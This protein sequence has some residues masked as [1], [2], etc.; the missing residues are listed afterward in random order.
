MPR[1]RRRR[2]RSRTSATWRTEIAAVGSS[3]STMRGSERRVRAM[4]TACRWPPDIRRTRSRGRVSDLS[5]RK[6]SPRGGSWRRGRGPGTGRPRRVSLAAEEDVRGGRQVVAEREV[7]VDDLDARRA[8]VARAGG[9]APARR[10]GGSR[11]W[12]GAEVAGD[13]LAPACDLPAPLSPMSPRTSPAPRSRV[14][15][16]Q[17]LDGAEAHRDA[18]EGKL[19]HA[20][21]PL[22]AARRRPSLILDLI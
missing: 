13:D 22:A 3:M 20:S 15:V 5:V 18:G 16:V 19:G 17:R 14:D 12:D 10:R 7:L 4:A 6:S 1:S 9:S 11:P 21:A 2:M 8:R